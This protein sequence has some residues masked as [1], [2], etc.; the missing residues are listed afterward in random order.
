M[1]IKCSTKDCKWCA[2]DDQ[3][4]NNRLVN[5]VR[6]GAVSSASCSGKECKGFELKN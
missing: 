3:C 4:G 5:Q 2:Q 1:A 6:T